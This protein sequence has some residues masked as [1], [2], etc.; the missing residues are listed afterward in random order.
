M[1]Q[2][3]FDGFLNHSESAGGNGW[4][5]EARQALAN[6][7][8]SVE[9]PK[10]PIGGAQAILMDRARGFLVGASDPRKDGLA[11]GL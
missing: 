9:V 5:D 2:R 8:H 4:K 6:M 3:R 7:G 10:E 11:I 1:R